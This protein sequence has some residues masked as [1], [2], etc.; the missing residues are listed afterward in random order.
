MTGRINIAKMPILFKEFYRFNLIHL[1][2]PMAFLTDTEK[3]ILKFV[4]KNKRSL[5]EQS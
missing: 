3:S 5:I 1:K 2:I 4:W